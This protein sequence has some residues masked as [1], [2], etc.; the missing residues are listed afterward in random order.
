MAT[1]IVVLEES[2]ELATMLAHLLEHAGFLASAATTGAEARSLMSESAPERVL[3]LVSSTLAASLG[4]SFNELLERDPIPL[5][6]LTCTQPDAACPLY[7]GS[8]CPNMD[9]L[10]KP[11]DFIAPVL[12]S[13]VSRVLATR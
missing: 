13:R 1:Q 2:V 3:L 6:A 10:R 7:P 4:T 9:C 12:I 11:Q 8:P 5:V